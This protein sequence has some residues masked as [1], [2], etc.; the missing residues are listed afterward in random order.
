MRQAAR[1]ATL[2]MLLQCNVTGRSEK[3]RVT[4]WRAQWL[5]VT[6]GISSR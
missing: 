4:R 2:E 6:D 3:Q 1:A 5:A